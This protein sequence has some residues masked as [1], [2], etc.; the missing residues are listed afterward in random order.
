MDQL[1]QRSRE[2][3]IGIAMIV[4]IP[5]VDLA[6]AAAPLRVEGMLQVVIAEV[7]SAAVVVLHP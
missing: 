3:T 2:P 7:A 4:L 1:S 6:V 5:I